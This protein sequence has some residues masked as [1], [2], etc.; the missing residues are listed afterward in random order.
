M[1]LAGGC[2]CGAVTYEIEHLAGD[3]AD[4]CHC[5]QCRKASGA[6]SVPWVQVAPQRF[7]VTRGAARGF[8]SSAHAMR[9]FCGD[10]GTP[11]YMTDDA[12]RSVGI[13]LGSLG[14][15]EKIRPTVH[16]WVGAKLSW[17]VLDEHLPRYDEAPPY[18]E[19]F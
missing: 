4:F 12:S 15:P 11:L 8:A 17:E 2:L 18:D 13:T 14:E 3:V 7:R 10:C 19:A 6:T 16:G 5:S 9:W 1:I